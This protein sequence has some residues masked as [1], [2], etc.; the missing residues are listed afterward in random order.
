MSGVSLNGTSWK[1]ASQRSSSLVKI[2]DC[3]S[4]K[5]HNTYRFPKVLAPG[6][7]PAAP[8]QRSLSISV[9]RRHVAWFYLNIMSV[10]VSVSPL[11]FGARGCMGASGP[12]PP[13]LP[14]RARKAGLPADDC[15]DGEFFFS[16]SFRMSIRRLARPYHLL[17]LFDLYKQF[18]IVRNC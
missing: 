10:S 12:A 6:P 5:V 15:R 16:S 1:R 8:A 3:F 13:S 14:T 7:R 17:S 9:P 11:P 2:S 4:V 18:C